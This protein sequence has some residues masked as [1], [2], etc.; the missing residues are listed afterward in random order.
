MESDTKAVEPKEE[1]FTNKKI[2]CERC[3]C[4]ILRPR[5]AKIIIKEVGIKVKFSL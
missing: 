1:E 2:V 4:V 3:S 5:Q